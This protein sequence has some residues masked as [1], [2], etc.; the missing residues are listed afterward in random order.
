MRWAYAWKAK[1]RRRCWKTASLPRVRW[2]RDSCGERDGAAK[3][4]ALTETTHE[5]IHEH[6]ACLLSD[7]EAGYDCYGAGCWHPGRT[8]RMAV[9]LHSRAYAERAFCSKPAWP[10]GYSD[11]SG[12]RAVMSS[13][14]LRLLPWPLTLPKGAGVFRPQRL[15][16]GSGIGQALRAIVARQRMLLRGV[17]SAPLERMAQSCSRVW[18]HREALERNLT[19]KLE[20]LPSCKYLYLLDAQ[21]HQT[22]ASVSTSMA[23]SA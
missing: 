21:A 17:L 20:A 18:P 19:D 4:S 22:T 13:H 3:R 15:G 7:A 1:Y 5:V 10:L 23:W 16:G 2:I 14:S 11:Q 9:P 6:D 8:W 12:L